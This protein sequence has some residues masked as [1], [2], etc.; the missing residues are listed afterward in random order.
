MAGVRE[1]AGRPVDPDCA[2]CILADPLQVFLDAHKDK[3]ADQIF[4]EMLQLAADFAAS[5]CLEEGQV[6][7]LQAGPT[8]LR[9]LM[10]QSFAGAKGYLRERN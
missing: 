8:L 4:G 9:R 7:A 3:P 10:V 5:T 2:H 6:D 1:L